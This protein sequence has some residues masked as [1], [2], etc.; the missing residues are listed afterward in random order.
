MLL[1][2]LLQCCVLLL[3]PPRVFQ[4]LQVL[5][6]GCYCLTALT[7][8]VLHFN[9]HAHLLFYDLLAFYTKLLLLLLSTT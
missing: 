6:P 3:S 7:P 1:L 5:P 8:P 4:P 2:L 9:W